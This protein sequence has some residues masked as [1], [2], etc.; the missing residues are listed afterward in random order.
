V[1]DYLEDPLADLVL[2]GKSR[3]RMR[4]KLAK[5]GKSIKF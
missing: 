2:S 3:P 5:D 4:A 1:Q